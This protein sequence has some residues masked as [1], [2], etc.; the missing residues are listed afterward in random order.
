MS[1]EKV[2]EVPQR[3]FKQV[4]GWAT[5]FT[6]VAITYYLLGGYK[7]FLEINDIQNNKNGTK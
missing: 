1:Q 3:I 5:V 7:Y 4:G 6:V 2:I